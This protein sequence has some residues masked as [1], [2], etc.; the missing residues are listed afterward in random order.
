MHFFRMNDSLNCLRCDGIPK[1]PEHVMI[2]YPRFPMKRMKLS[3]ALGRIV[4][5][6]GYICED[7][8]IERKMAY[9]LLCNYKNAAEVAEGEK[10]K[11][12]EREVPKDK[13][14]PRGNT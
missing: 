6:E 8:E 7:A 4:N 14:T 11:K 2:H 13:P 1:D 10:E 5:P 3:P 9:S 12:A